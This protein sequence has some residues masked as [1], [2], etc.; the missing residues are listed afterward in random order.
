MRAL[1]TTKSVVITITCE[2]ILVGVVIVHA[3][4]KC[5]REISSVWR[6]HYH[7]NHIPT[8]RV[9]MSI[10]RPT[11]AFSLCELEKA[12]NTWWQKSSRLTC[13]LLTAF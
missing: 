3:L 10:A 1:R 9:I 12:V 8:A 6:L 13:A 11:K 5:G 2:L 4:E 7:F